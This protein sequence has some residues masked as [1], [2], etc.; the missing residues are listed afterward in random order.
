MIA[1]FTRSSILSYVFVMGL[2]LRVSSVSGSK[3][4]DWPE[5]NKLQRGITP[6]KVLLSHTVQVAPVVGICVHFSCAFVTVIVSIYVDSTLNF[7]FAFI[8]SVPVTE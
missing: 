1:G 4:K 2:M 3:T 5:S 6:T 7:S 8:H